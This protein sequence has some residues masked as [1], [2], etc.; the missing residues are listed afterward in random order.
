MLGLVLLFLAALGGRDSKC[1]PSTTVVQQA[2]VGFELVD[3]PRADGQPLHGAFWYP[4]TSA[5]SSMRVG[6]A[7]QIVAKNGTIVGSRLPL[8]VI[9]VGALG[10]WSGHS[11]TAISLAQAGFVVAS[12]TYDEVGAGG[13][14]KAFGLPKQFRELIDYALQGWHGGDHLDPARIG[15]FGFSLG[16][17]AV[18]AAVGGTPTIERIASH[19][20]NAPTEWSCSLAAAHKLDLALGPP[21]AG[22]FAVDRRI[23]AAVIVAPALGYLFDDHGLDSVHIPIQLWQA[24]RDTVLAEPWNSQAVK[25]DLPLPPEYHLVQGADHGDFTAPCAPDIAT[26]IPQICRGKSGFD[27]ELFHVSLNSAIVHFFQKSLIPQ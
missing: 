18:L 3:I 8:I 13:L 21:Q 23:K 24:S 22:A 10:T 9:S 5:A 15:A 11:D 14:L 1:S 17:F 25:R 4:S 16:G 19:C 7:N 27:R 26:K 12:V 6:W 2:T 20:R